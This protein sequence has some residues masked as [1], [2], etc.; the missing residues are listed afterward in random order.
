VFCDL[1]GFEPIP[2]ASRRVVLLSPI[3]GILKMYQH[4]PVDRAARI[5]KFAQ[6]HSFHAAWSIAIAAAVLVFVAGVT[7]LASR[8][9]GSS[10]DP[11]SAGVWSL[12]PLLG[13]RPLNRSC[14]EPALIQRAEGA[15]SLSPAAVG[16]TIHEYLV[17]T[18]DSHPA[19]IAVDGLGQVW[20]TEQEGNKIARLEP[21]TGD[22]QEYDIPTPGS[23]PWG[24]A[25]DSE[26]NVWFAATQSNCIGRLER[27][28]GTITEY[29]LPNPGSEPWDLA[30]GA[31]DFVLFT[32]RAGNRIG[33]LDPSTGA[34]T[35][36]AIPTA[37]AQPGGIAI[38]GD[39]LYFVE[40]AVN[41]LGWLYLSDPVVFED[42]LLPTVNSA[43]MDVA[44]GAAG[45]PWL[46]ESEGNK[47]ALFAPSTVTYWGEV[48][49]ATVGSKPY[50]IATEGNVAVWFTQKD[51]NQLGRYVG[52]Q[53]PHEY[54]LPLPSRSPTGIALDDDGCAW[55]TAPA[56]NRVGQLCLHL[57]YTHMP[58]VSRD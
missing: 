55:Y 14:A 34:I 27:A 51:A 50:G 7:A 49:A 18:A 12:P 29:P 33:E 57:G 35:E 46:T 20:I 30:L 13:Q 1:P 42:F 56:V 54:S 40:T 23:R 26:D 8:G 41:R 38:A 45:N 36:Y 19:Q 9:Q 52:H 10:A 58:L 5:R 16:P 22:W 4:Q 53:P 11:V 37:N 32:Q 24:L 6:F 43:P 25:I 39:H 15:T 21:E 3:G 48:P 47:I 31:G 44:V 17:P 28:S 2:C